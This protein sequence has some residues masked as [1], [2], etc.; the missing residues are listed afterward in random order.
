MSQ[1]RRS[2]LWR[3]FWRL[4]D[5]ARRAVFNLLFLALLAVLLIGLLRDAR[6]VVVPGSA[7]VIAPVGVLSDQ[8]SS[9]DPLLLWLATESQPLE[10]RLLDLIDAIDRAAD[11]ERIPMLVLQLDGLQ[12]G[13][14]SKLQELAAAVQ[15]FRATGKPVIA[16]GDSYT[17]DQYFLAAHADEVLLDPMGAVQLEGYGV[18]QNYFRE[19]LEKLSIDINVFRIGEYKSAME[20]FTRNDMSEAARRANLAWLEDLW[21]QYLQAV[22]EYRRIAPDALAQ[23]ADGY[24]EHL[25]AAG[26]DAAQTALRAGLVDRLMSRSASNAYLQAQLGSTVDDDFPAVDVTTYLAATDAIVDG[27]PIVGLITASGMIADGE[28]PLGTVGGDTLAG[29]LR[30]AR[31]DETVRAVVLR[32][33]SGGGSAHASEVIRQEILDLKRAGKPVVVSMG[34]VAASGGYWIAANAD[35]IWATPASLT[36]SIGIFG[37]LPTVE[38]GLQQLGIHTD[39]VGTTQLAGGF[40]P[41]RPLSDSHR[42]IIQQELERGYQRFI[43]LVA[44]GRDM[45]VERVESIA[46]GRVWSGLAAQDIGLVDELGGL[47]DAQRVAAE[48]AGLEDSQLISIEPPLSAPERILRELTGVATRALV[49]VMAPSLRHT[50]AALLSSPI[51][52]HYQYSMQ[53]G[54]SILAGLND[55]RGHYLLCSVC[56]AP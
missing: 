44:A 52:L 32:I 45:S 4:V 27:T 42:E 15:R 10:T 7:L 48:L 14:L 24:A 46:Q 35:Q 30:S 8:L 5:G 16:T 49:E 36:G 28:Q 54:G 9:I 37:A 40:R 12:G 18:Y 34:S 23:Y 56:S 19:A 26:G 2:G 41:D 17:Q 33:D 13:G 6:P 11:D 38:R 47:R 39:G 29:L 50:T 20:P 51:W 55:P 25:A 22:A 3:R 1:Q 31:L 21:Q 43:D 53:Y